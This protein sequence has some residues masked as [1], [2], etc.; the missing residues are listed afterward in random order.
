MHE[1]LLR[2]VKVEDLKNCKT[3]RAI[4]DAMTKDTIDGKKII[5]DLR[6]GAR[7]KREWS[8]GQKGKLITKIL[9][10]LDAFEGDFI[11][12]ELD[13]QGVKTFRDGDRYEGHFVHGQIQGFGVLQ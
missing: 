5:Q 13:G 10:N 7:M 6:D 9:P 2:K 1:S 8:N 3:I 11:D 4:R 12:D